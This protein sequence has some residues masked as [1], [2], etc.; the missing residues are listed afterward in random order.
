MV[1][2]VLENLRKQ[3]TEY[4]DLLNYTRNREIIEFTEKE[5]IDKSIESFK[6]GLNKNLLGITD[7]NE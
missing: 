6:R 2:E 1:E 3:G 5:I 7:P 4:L